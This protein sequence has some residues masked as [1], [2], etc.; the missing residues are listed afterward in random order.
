MFP[1]FQSSFTEQE[2]IKIEDK[3]SENSGYLKNIQVTLK[4]ATQNRQYLWNSLMANEGH[5]TDLKYC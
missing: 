5:K 3:N 1:L 4:V 2:F